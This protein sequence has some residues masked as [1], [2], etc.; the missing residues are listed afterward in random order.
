MQKKRILIKNLE[1]VLKT[2]ILIKML[3]KILKKKKQILI[4]N[5]EKCYI[6]PDIHTYWWYYGPC[7]H[8][9]MSKIPKLA[10]YMTNASHCWCLLYSNRVV[11][12]SEQDTY[13][14][15]ELGPMWALLNFQNIETYV[16]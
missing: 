16:L 4:K 9:F 2:R 3:E 12:Y 5:L 14:L 7:G 11:Q 15:V 6:Q 8:C 13:L 10:C 1:K